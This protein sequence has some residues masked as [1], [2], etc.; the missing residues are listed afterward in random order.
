MQMRKL[1]DSIRASEALRQWLGDERVTYLANSS[2]E[3]MDVMLVDLSTPS[4][5][6][7]LAEA[8]RRAFVVLREIIVEYATAEGATL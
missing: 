6:S 8:K 2:L 5:S 3:E 7:A 1:R 4:Q